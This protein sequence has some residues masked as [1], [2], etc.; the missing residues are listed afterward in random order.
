[1]IKLL[2]PS[3][4]YTDEYN[5]WLESLPNYIYPIIFII[6]RFYKPEWQGNWRQHAGVDIV[7]GFAGHELKYMGRR[8]VGTYLRVGLM[9]P[10]AWRTYKLR[11]DFAAATK[12]QTEDDITASVVV[13][14]S[15]LSYNDP[16]YTSGPAARGSFK[17]AVN[18]EYRLFQRPDDAVHRGLDKQTEADMSRSD[19]FISNFEPLTKVDAADMVQRVVDFD[20]F[21]PPMQTLISRA[22]SD[23]DGYAV[24]SA[25]P[26]LVNGQP[27]KNP[28]YLQIRPDLLNQMSLHVADQGL[29]FLRALPVDQP[30]YWPVHAV[31]VGRRNNPAEPAANI[32]A[33]AVYN[34]IHYQELPELFMDFIS[35][36]TGKSPSTTG[37]GSEGR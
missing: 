8:L 6:K 16:A 29:R 34:P 2:T 21:T 26:R 36:L 5:Q 37:A 7:N 19:N 20:K 32:R 31:L 27:S 3:S 4:D 30:V 10:Q 24:C 33:L 35:S 25:N 22:A 9:P 11:Q 14:A 18:T 15:Q 23:G 13:P 12:I 17:F 1:M 28:R